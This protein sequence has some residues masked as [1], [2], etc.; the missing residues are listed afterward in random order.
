MGKLLTCPFILYI[1]FP[2]LVSA[3]GG[4]RHKSLSELGFRVDLKME[5]GRPHDWSF[6]RGGRTVQVPFYYCSGDSQ[7]GENF[8]SYV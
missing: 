4:S 8:D 6:V 7:N 5:Q 3:E 1:F 2:V